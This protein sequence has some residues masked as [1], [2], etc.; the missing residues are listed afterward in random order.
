[1]SH[2]QLPTGYWVWFSLQQVHTIMQDLERQKRFR[3]TLILLLALA[4]MRVSQTGVFNNSF[5][6]PMTFIPLVLK[7]RCE[8]SSGFLLV[9]D[10]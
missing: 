8:A 6:I 9:P 1:M 2:T 7:R 10:L 5:R 3:I 4:D